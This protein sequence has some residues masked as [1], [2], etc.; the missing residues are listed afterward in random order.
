MH[1][2]KHSTKRKAARALVVIF[3]SYLEP[4][5]SCGLPPPM[6]PDPFQL[7]FLFW[8][9][10]YPLGRATLNFRTYSELPDSTRIKT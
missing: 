2:E 9:S 3:E 5:P 1:L 8:I 10:R 7:L 4:R 6:E